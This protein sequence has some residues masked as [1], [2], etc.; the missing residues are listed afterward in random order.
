M[1]THSEIVVDGR[2]IAYRE[3]G[4]VDAPVI[5]LLHAL[6]SS[7]ATWEVVAAALAQR[8]WRTI[9]VDLR[10]H[11]RSANA[12]GYAMDDFWPD[13][14]AL[15]DRLEIARVHLVAHS[16]GGH[17][18][19][20]LAAH[21]PERVGRLVLEEP[22][23]PLDDAT[24]AERGAGAPGWRRLAKLLGLARLARVLLFNRFDLRVLRPVLG[25]V[26]AADPAFSALLAKLRAPTLVLAAEPGGAP[27]GRYRRLVDRL[28]DARFVA[29]GDSHHLHREHPQRFVELVA[30]FLS[31]APPVVESAR[32]LGT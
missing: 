18:A 5:L 21:R 15:L 9:A 4:P 30:T 26:R 10:G 32:R 1:P 6:A 31:A 23:L 25:Y 22:A 17:V 13:L 2:R 12:P 7:S 29:L 27:A 3:T 11:G 8:G 19:L 14:V 28:H 16:L 20:R 24:G